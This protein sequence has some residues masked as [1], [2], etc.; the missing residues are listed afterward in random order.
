MNY[1]DGDFIPFKALQN[2]SDAYEG[3]ID[4]MDT[5]PEGSDVLDNLIQLELVKNMMEDK[6]KNKNEGQTFLNSYL[7]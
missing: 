6:K 3:Y 4:L 7:A 2:P 1:I 5:Q